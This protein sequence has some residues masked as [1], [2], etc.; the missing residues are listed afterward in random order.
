MFHII[1]FASLHG[2]SFLNFFRYSPRKR[3]KIGA[4][5][6][7]H[8]AAAAARHFSNKMGTSV[9]EST[10]KSIE[11][12]YKEELRKQRAGTG[13]SVVK[14]LPEKKRGRTLL[15]GDE[16]DKKLQLYLRRIREDGGLV[17]A[18]V[19]IAAA[20]GLLMAEH[21]NRLVENGGHIKLNRHWA[22][23][24]FQRMGFVQ[25]K[26]TTAKSKFIVENF[27]AK[28][29][30]FLDDLV[31][32]VEMEEIPA[33][34]ILNWDQTG[35]RLVPSSTWTM[36]QRGIK[37]VE[38]V[39]QNDKRRITAVFCGSIQGDFLPVQVIYKGKT[40][41]CHPH[42]EFPPGWHVTH[43]PKHWST[44]TTMLQYIEHIIE[45]YVRTVRDML[46]TVTTPGVIIMDNFKGQVTEKVSS[47][48]EKHHL[49]VC[50][51]PAN[52]TDLQ[53]PMDISVNK[54]V[55]SFLKEQ[56]S[57][58]YSEQLFK[59]FEDQSDVPLDDVTLNPVDLS[60]ANVKNIGA[61]W[62]VE[63]AK[64]IANNPQFIVNGFVR[65]GIC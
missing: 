4:Y 7:L 31:T 8:G 39:G 42:F 28:K 6:C 52:T 57:M 60:L 26:P 10:I 33:K 29:K 18:G 47:L 32:T 27:A 9:S 34:L 16:L 58:W 59:Q 43:S 30:E 25:R 20:R 37:R 64:Y 45:P 54:P 35:I 14:S 11:I 44:E 24:F 21:R 13:S 36:E 41:R 48:L 3:A 12:C 46:Y 53:Q 17:T 55:K 51:L 5:A 62:L 49:H 63:A 22:Y 65:A 19:A 1:L 61:K 2:T 40:M 50:L 23:G 15:L 56:F 38:M